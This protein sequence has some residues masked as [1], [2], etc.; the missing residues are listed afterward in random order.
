MSRR[1]QILFLAS[2]YPS[3][4]DKTSGLFV[5]NHAIEISKNFDVTTLSFHI[6]REGRL[7]WW[8]K[9]V[10]N[11]VSGL[12]ECRVYI[13]DLGKIINLF[14][15]FFLA[16]SIL[17][18]RL[19]LHWGRIS[20]V[21]LNVVYHLGVFVFPVL[22]L[23]RKP[24]VVTEH[25]TGYFPEDGRFDKL[26]SLVKWIIR[27]IYGMSSAVV[28]ISNSLLR[29]LDELF[30]V[31]SKTKLVA[32]FLNVPDSPREQS[33][34]PNGKCEV[35]SVCYM[36]DRMKGVS[37]LVKAFHQVLS[38]FPQA[39]LTILGGGADLDNLMLLS[40]KLGLTENQLEFRGFV[41]NDV[42]QKF[43]RSSSFFVLNSNFETFSIATAEALLNGLPVLV[44]KCRGPEE[45]VDTEMGLLIEKGNDLALVKGLEEM[46]DRWRTYDSA[47]IHNLAKAKLTSVSISD[48]F[49]GVFNN[50]ERN[51]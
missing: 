32:N 46:I 40:R 44:T 4:V 6:I 39:K 36:D 30:A 27:K 49:K 41:S 33:V 19:L 28:V 11:E 16:N 50:I 43:Y 48:S 5:R 22:V 12:T 8:K 24:L 17:M 3:A 23:F 45:Y 7:F 51:N 14:S 37:A 13:R 21:N 10:D 29:Q 2:W 18:G 15:L 38:V 47:K 9:S 35:L 1:K 34:I 26:G 31:G 25:W 20:A 42:V